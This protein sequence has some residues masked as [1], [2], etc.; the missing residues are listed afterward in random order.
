[1][2][3]IEQPAK[4][5][6]WF[7][8]G[9]KDLKDTVVKAWGLNQATV[10][11]FRAKL[12]LKAD[13]GGVRK[14]AWRFFYWGS[15]VAVY[16][17]GSII[18][19]IVSA[20]NF[21][22]IVALM[23]CVYIG[24]T[25]I[26][27][28]DRTYL[29]KN[30]IFTACHA[31]KEKS[32]IPAYKC[33]QCGTVHTKLV[34]GVYGILNRKCTGDGTTTCGQKLPTSFLNG[35]NKLEAI[36][37]NCGTPL[38]DRETRPIA[39]PIVGGRSAGKTA[40]ITSAAVKFIEDEAPGCGLE[41]EMYNDEKTIIYNRMKEAYRKG[42]TENTL[43]SN[44][45]GNMSGISS[46]S[47]SF[48]TKHR[49]LKPD[50]LLHI[51]DISGEFFTNNEEQEVQKQYEY[52][53]GLVLIVDPLAIQSIFDRFESTLSE[54][55]KTRRGDAD[56]T[57]IVDTFINKIRDVTGLSDTKMNSTPLAVVITKIDAIPEI[58]RQLSFAAAEALQKTDV[59]K[60]KTVYD[61]QDYLCRQFF[62][63]NDMRHF[64]TTINLHFK[65]NRFFSCSPIGHSA[66]EGEFQ[67]KGVLPIMEW[68][69]KNAD[70][71]LGELCKKNQFSKEPP[72][73]KEVR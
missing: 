50:R 30:K 28:I 72:G 7:E 23:F 66:G 27:V 18:T 69:L 1:M 19:G 16:V 63:K 46:V 25:V 48:F 53:H 11:G 59:E 44:S 24:F 71:K 5:S 2:A 32:L 35:R 62:L 4:K 55:D 45:S 58:D 14:W 26:W 65:N 6:Y 20:I 40:F 8:K 43:T 3:A 42:D 68:L 54:I 9:Y 38:S 34:P 67:P 57:V 10:K 64:L 31:C 12:S 29:E 61:A 73:F 70:S 37:A 41:I 51:Y 60:F 21:L 39:I 22:V 15:I 36:C 13:A 33:P 47:L 56:I 49:L 52:C 17:F